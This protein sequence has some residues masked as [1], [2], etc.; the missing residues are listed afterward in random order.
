MIK[1]INPVDADVYFKYMCPT[2]TCNNEHWTSLIES[3]TEGFKIVCD[4]C[5]TVFSPKRIKSITINFL[6]QKVQTNP[7]NPPKPIDDYGFVDE[8]IDALIR[9][10]FNR[11]EARSMIMDE[12]KKT[13]ETD[14][15]KLVKL[16]FNL[17]GGKNG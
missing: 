13:G 9:L 7:T 5:G 16:A 4:N 11:T 14:P 10:G 12:W 8:A 3:K 2:K 1:D 15:G 17:L 6:T